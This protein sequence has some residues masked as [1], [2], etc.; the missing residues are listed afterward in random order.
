MRYGPPII[1]A[2]QPTTI[3]YACVAKTTWRRSETSRPC[4]ETSRRCSETSGY[5]QVNKVMGV[6]PHFGC[7]PGAGELL[8]KCPTLLGPLNCGKFCGNLFAPARFLVWYVFHDV[9]VGLVA[10]THFWLYLVR[11]NTAIALR[12]N[13]WR[14]VGGDPCCW[15]LVPGHSVRYLLWGGLGYP[16]SWCW[17][18][19]IGIINFVTPCKVH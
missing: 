13:R 1:I 7:P 8:N 15:Q 5:R 4:S 9:I 17:V 18:G 3:I 14:D 2:K 12:P 6:V 19:S 11:D 10:G 16:S